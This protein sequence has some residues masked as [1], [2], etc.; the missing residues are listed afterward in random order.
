[1]CLQVYKNGAR[2]VCVGVPDK[3]KN[4]PFQIAT[5]ISDR[6]NIKK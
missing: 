2:L 3:R 1:M 6:K 5:P 4:T